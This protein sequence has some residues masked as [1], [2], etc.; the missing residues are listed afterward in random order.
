MKIFIIYPI[1]LV[2]SSS[3]IYPNIDDNCSLAIILLEGLLHCWRRVFLFEHLF[4]CF[5]STAGD[6]LTISEM[7]DPQIYDNFISFNQIFE[8]KKKKEDNTV[9]YH[10]EDDNQ[11]SY[12]PT[13]TITIPTD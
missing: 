2:N 8:K 10:K 13:P 6:A 3:N 4:F 1:L 11:Q 7:L 12:V 9:M 5:Y